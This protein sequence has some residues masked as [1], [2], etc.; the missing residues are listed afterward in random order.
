MRGGERKRYRRI[1]VIY[2]RCSVQFE[3]HVYILYSN[4]FRLFA[5]FFCVLSI[6]L[7]SFFFSSFLSLSFSCSF[8]FCCYWTFQ[9]FC[10]VPVRLINISPH[11]YKCVYIHSALL[12]AALIVEIKRRGKLFIRFSSTSMCVCVPAYLSAFFCFLRARFSINSA[13]YVLF[14]S[15]RSSLGYNSALCTGASVGATS[16]AAAAA[17]FVIVHSCYCRSVF[18][19]WVHFIGALCNSDSILFLIDMC[20]NSKFLKPN[21]TYKQHFHRRTNQSDVHFSVHSVTLFRSLSL[22]FFFR[23]VLFILLSFRVL[24]RRLDCSLILNNNEN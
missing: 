5:T 17:A 20:M 1:L 21:L 8:S 15:L 4:L 16:V 13:F 10:F 6:P 11:S 23:F 19:S 24:I 3:L 14:S 12:S 18:C 9:T 7:D 2:T 22:S